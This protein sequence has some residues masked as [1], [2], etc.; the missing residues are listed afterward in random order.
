MPEAIQQIVAR[1]PRG[2]LPADPQ[3]IVNAVQE[4]EATMS[5]YLGNGL[6]V[7]HG[8]LDNLERPLLVFARSD[9]ALRSISPTNEL[10]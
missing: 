10:S 7:P 4:R 2:E 1:I 6:A 9:E 3:I 5:T 8:R